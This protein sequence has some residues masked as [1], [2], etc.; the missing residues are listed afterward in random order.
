MARKAPSKLRKRF[1]PIAA[2]LGFGMAAFAAVAM[3]LDLKLISALRA[4]SARAEA[5]VPDAGADKSDG[6]RR[7]YPYSIIP[8]GAE[9]VFAELAASGSMS[10]LQVG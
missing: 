6:A 3:G 4:G 8:G 7:V 2:A 10:M 1:V 9:T 5:P